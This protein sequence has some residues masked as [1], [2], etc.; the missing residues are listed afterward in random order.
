VGL[1]S[2]GRRCVRYTDTRAA[3]QIRMK[4]GNSNIER[5]EDNAMSTRRDLVEYRNS[6]GSPKFNFPGAPPGTMDRDFLPFL[7]NG[8]IELIPETND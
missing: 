5:V 4:P 8:G 1:R 7:P 6:P 3:T 2:G